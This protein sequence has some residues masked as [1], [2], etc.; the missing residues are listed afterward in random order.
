MCGR[1][2]RGERTWSDC[3]RLQLPGLFPA[4]LRGDGDGSPVGLGE[5]VQG[6][7]LGVELEAARPEQKVEA[8]TRAGVQ[9]SL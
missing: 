8:G 5:P 9:A 4:A 7:V 2:K 6:P 1:A 3:D